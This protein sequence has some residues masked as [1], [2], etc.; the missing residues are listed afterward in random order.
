MPALP[1]TPTDA[2]TRRVPWLTTTGEMATIATPQSSRVQLSEVMASLSHA[3]DL[4]EGQPVGHSIR[5]CLIAMR[6]A[7]ELGLAA[8]QRSA[9]YYAM[10]LKDAG[11][12]SN[13]ARIAT[14]FGADDRVVKPRM[15]IV[16]WH[17]GFR[18]A[19]E[20]LRTAGLRHFL[21]IART[22]NTTRDLIQ[23]RCDR[24]AEIARRLGF[25]DATADAIRSL[26]EHWN[27]RGYPAGL[28]G[29]DIPLLSRIANIAQTVEVVL[30]AEG[31]EAAVSIVRQ[32]RGTW[33]DPALVDIV[34]SWRRDASWWSSVQSPDVIA[35]VVDSEP[36][37]HVR[38]VSGGELEGVARAFADIIDAKSPYTYRHSTRVA[39]IA[40]G[41]A[42]VAG[43]DG[44][45]QDRLFR[46]GLLH[47]IGKLGV[48][49][50]ILDKP[51]ALTA[52]ERAAVELHPLHT[53]EILSRVSAFAELAPVASAHHE[54]LDGSG[55]P[56]GLTADQLDFP[57][58][59][60]A[61]ADIYEALTA[62]RPYRAG[63]TRE[64]ALTIIARDRRAR[65]CSKAIDAL[66]AHTVELD[67]VP[68]EL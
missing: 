67:D 13:A 3:L 28:I 10:L 20:T 22:E 15:K 31:A 44:L 24:G 62:N 39:D 48:S 27:G 47:D 50:R 65:L 43:L 41:V 26:D 51:A 66:E 8:Q 56:W 34:A 16:D 36:F 59:I 37:D 60:L 7:R 63:M 9:L 4:T 55:Y 17:H 11:C 49:S 58:R 57:S 68:T 14:L 53:W 52:E 23:I 29:D 18:L 45:A 1:Q 35:A 61:V 33:F 42:S 19:V 46:A 38:I 64:A 54:K 5:S 25:P 6:I 30:A 12:S 32:R 21:G 2:S 40:R